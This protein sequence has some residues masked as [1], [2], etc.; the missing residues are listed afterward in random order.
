MICKGHAR[1]DSFKQNNQTDFSM[2]C[3]VQKLQLAEDVMT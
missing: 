2:A 1:T 3:F